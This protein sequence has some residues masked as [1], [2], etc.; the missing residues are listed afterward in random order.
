MGSGDDEQDA[1]GN[2]MYMKSVNSFLS[3][4]RNVHR[5]HGAAEIPELSVY[6]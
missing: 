2:P 3:W 6:I 1:V 5:C 4:V